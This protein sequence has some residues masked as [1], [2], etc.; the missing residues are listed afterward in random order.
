[1]PTISRLTKRPL[2][3]HFWGGVQDTEAVR[4]RTFERATIS[5]ER[6]LVVANEL[7]NYSAEVDAARE[8]V[9]DE[10]AAVHYRRPV[11]DVG[12]RPF[13]VEKCCAFR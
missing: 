11:H 10:E 2:S 7:R 3:K 5:P 12:L 6:K 1:M 4:V 13:L 8:P 9:S